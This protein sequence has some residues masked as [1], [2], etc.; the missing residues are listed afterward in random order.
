MCKYICVV[1]LTGVILFTFS[2]H[3]TYIQ[4]GDADYITQKMFSD[5]EQG[6]QIQ[7]QV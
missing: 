5:V 1:Y 7:V 3:P 4:V 6:F 2:S